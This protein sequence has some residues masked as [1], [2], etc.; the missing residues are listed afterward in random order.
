MSGKAPTFNTEVVKALLSQHF[1]QTNTKLGKPAAEA[2]ANF[3][4]LFTTEAFN[5]AAKLAKREAAAGA[6]GDDAFDDDESHGF[7]SVG[8][9]VGE[10]GALLAGGSTQPRDVTVTPDHIR[11]ILPALLLDF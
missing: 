1:S 6:A 9:S 11:R 3:V 5:R 10:H 8:A 4:Q 2:A 7:M